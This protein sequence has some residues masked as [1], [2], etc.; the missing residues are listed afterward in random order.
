MISQEQVFSM[1]IEKRTHLKS[2]K[3]QVK[4]KLNEEIS[5]GIIRPSM[6]FEEVISNH[7]KYDHIKNFKM[8]KNSC[9]EL[10]KIVERIKK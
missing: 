5:L 3:N 7:I 4:Y 9:E 2:W 1:M 10:K 8:P 6:S